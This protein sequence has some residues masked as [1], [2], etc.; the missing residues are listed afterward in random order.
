M[1]KP[2]A[3]WPW[4][5][6][7]LLPLIWLGPRLA[8]SQTTLTS[9]EESQSST[10]G[11]TVINGVIQLRSSAAQA[12]CSTQCITGLANAFNISEDLVACLCP[13][14]SSSSTRRRLFGL[15]ARGDA[16]LDLRRDRGL[17]EEE[18]VMGAAFATR[19]TGGLAAG[20]ESLELFLSS[21]ALVA[22]A[23]A[24]DES[25]V[26][27]LFVFKCWTTHHNV[28]SL[29]HSPPS[30][31]GN[32]L[33]NNF[34]QCDCFYVP[35][36]RRVAPIMPEV[37]VSISC[38]KCGALLVHLSVIVAYGRRNW[39]VSNVGASC[40]QGKIEQGVGGSVYRPL[41]VITEIFYFASLNRAGDPVL[42]VLA[43]FAHQPRAH[44]MHCYRPPACSSVTAT[45]FDTHRHAAT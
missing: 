27:V 14:D 8:S 10:G 36:S 5:Y 26:R 19:I 35:I 39:I 23:F 25:D 37:L 17:A 28:D 45:V 6:L 24:V 21:T 18:D 12:A 16:D 13:M 30:L 34:I 1:I 29:S 43:S 4:M 40:H 3:M 15:V 33:L 44:L 20:I 42:A 41:P 11:D 31:T 32:F 22:E 2:L 7:N 9:G 38:R